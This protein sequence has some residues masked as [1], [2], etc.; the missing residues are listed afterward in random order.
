MNTNKLL[1]TII[2][3]TCV[4][5]L[6]FVTYVGKELLPSDSISTMSSSTQPVET[7]PHKPLI[8]LPEPIPTY[9]NL[10]GVGDNLIHSSIYIQAGRR[11]TA[12][13][14]YDFGLSYENIQDYIS[15]ADIASLNQ[16]TMMAKSYEPSSYPTFN[17]PTELGDLMVD[18]GFDVINLANNHMLDKGEKG[19]RETLE[20][21]NSKED[22]VVVGA[23]LNEE[24]YLNIPT[25][26]HEDIV[27]SFI[28]ATETLNGL[29]LPSSSD[30]YLGF[31]KSEEQI[32]ELV[33]QVKRA[34]LI[35]DVVV[36]NIHWGTEYTH[37]PTDF[38]VQVA[39]RLVTAGADVILGHHPHVIQP[40]EY[41]TKPN[42][43]NAVVCYSLGNFISVQDS[44]L[45]MIGGMLDIEFEKLSGRTSIS[46]VEFL[47]VITHYGSG[48]SNVTIYPY[49]QYTT[50][51]ASSHGVKF[52]T[53]SFSHEYIY[54]TIVSVIDSQFIPDD[55]YDMFPYKEAE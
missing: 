4:I 34:Y 27:F 10:L 31:V 30:L 7:E 38:Q 46:S 14:K 52:Y 53:P 49:D 39:E 21:L 8:E 2:T 3:I 37:T 45:R 44:G 40:V 19:L 54:N 9:A 17:S 24:E 1:R 13:L 22:L 12:D 6:I 20:F 32:E 55:F 23:Y 48:M 25:I 11:A 29:T 42:G 51:L 15:S 43:S 47:P 28:G 26:T 33:E 18:I 16:E 5:S 50:E 36:V 41:L 35:S